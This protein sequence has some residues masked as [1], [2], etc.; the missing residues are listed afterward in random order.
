M[1]PAAA[2]AA[3]LTRVSVLYHLQ[4]VK[5]QIQGVCWSL[6]RWRASSG[7]AFEGLSEKRKKWWGKR[8]LPVNILFKSELIRIEMF[9]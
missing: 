7:E 6:N 3:Y 5:I 9:I 8:P 2:V 4:G 1:F